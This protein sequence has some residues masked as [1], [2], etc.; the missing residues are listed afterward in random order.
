M[1]AEGPGI[2]M[3]LKGNL[4]FL[5]VWR[6]QANSNKLQTVVMRTRVMLTNHA[7]LLLKSGCSRVVLEN[8]E[9]KLVHIQTIK[10]KI[11]DTFIPR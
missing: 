3:E 8:L 6:G 4:T 2:P 1:G 11:K 10:I 7:N 9:I 5:P